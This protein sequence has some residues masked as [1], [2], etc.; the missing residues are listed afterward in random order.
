MYTTITIQ[1]MEEFLKFSKGWSKICPKGQEVCFMRPAFGCVIKVYSSIPSESSMELHGTSRKKGRDAIRVC[2]TTTTKD[3]REV[4]LS[5]FPRVT[6]QTNWRTHLKHRV[7]EA[8]VQARDLPVCSRCG[9][10]MVL[11]TA[12]VSSNQ[13][14]G[15][16]RYPLCKSTRDMGD[17]ARDV[18][19][20]AQEARLEKAH[21]VEVPQPPVPLEY[22]QLTLDFE[23]SPKKKGLLRRCLNALFMRL[24]CTSK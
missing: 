12:K 9:S 16:S 8:Y 2:L 15:C 14:Y 19:L 4:A 24:K 21:L 17:Y 13:F 10:K 20:A 7:M 18:T 23:P 3:G 11:R 1:E 5:K 22:S 6:R